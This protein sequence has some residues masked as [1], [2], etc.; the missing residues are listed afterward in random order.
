MRFDQIIYG[1]NYYKDTL[2][3]RNKIMRVP[4]GLNIYDEDLT[5]EKDSYILGAFSQKDLLGFG[6]LSRTTAPYEFKVNFLCVDN[7]IQSKGVGSA[8]LTRL[9]KYVRLKGASSVILEARSS[10]ERFYAK[11]GYVTISQPYFM[12]SAPVPHKKMKKQ[13]EMD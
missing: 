4:L 1:T 9:E 5:Q 7:E 10:T 8:I 2:R 3:L 13:L 6:V 12:E 11:Y